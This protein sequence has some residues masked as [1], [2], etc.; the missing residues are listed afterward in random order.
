MANETVA[1]YY[2]HLT[3]ELVRVEFVYVCDYNLLKTESTLTF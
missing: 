2:L 3:P 1:A